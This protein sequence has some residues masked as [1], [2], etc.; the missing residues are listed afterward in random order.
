MGEILMRNIKVA[1]NKLAGVI[2]YVTN[3]TRV[4]TVRISD[5]LIVGVSTGNGAAQRGDIEP[6]Y[7]YK[8]YM[9]VFTPVVDGLSYDNMRFHNFNYHNENYYGAAIGTCAYCDGNIIENKLF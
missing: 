1:D 6:T 3:N 4:G 7:Y 9:G 5:G 8:G 2:V